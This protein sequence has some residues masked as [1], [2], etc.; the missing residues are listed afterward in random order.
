MAEPEHDLTTVVEVVAEKEWT[1]RLAAAPIAEESKAQRTWD[2]LP[3]M[4]KHQLK[5]ELLPLVTDVL[6]ALRRP[7]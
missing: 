5:N 4:A 1:R 7:S 2:K 6:E 3:A